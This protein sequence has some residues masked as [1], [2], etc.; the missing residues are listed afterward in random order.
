MLTHSPKTALKM[1]AAQTKETLDSIRT[2]AGT[3]DLPQAKP[4]TTGRQEKL[5]EFN[6]EIFACKAGNSVQTLWVTKDLPNYANV[7]EQLDRLY[8]WPEPPVQKG[9]P[10]DLPGLP[11]VVV[12]TEMEASGKKST[13]TVLSVKEEDLDAVLFEMPTDYRELAKAAPPAPAATPSPSK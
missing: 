6:T 8:R 9:V 1:S 5:G 7:K 12:K 2:T 11:G 13:W 3:S 10:S 4:E